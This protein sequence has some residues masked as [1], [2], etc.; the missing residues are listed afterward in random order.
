MKIICDIQN[1]KKTFQL[2]NVFCRFCQ[3]IDRLRG[4]ECSWTNEEP[5]KLWKESPF[6]LVIVEK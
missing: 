3:I 4:L 1:E 6:Q 5:L 2:F